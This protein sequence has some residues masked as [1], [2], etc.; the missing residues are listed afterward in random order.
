MPPGITTVLFPSTKEAYKS[1]LRWVCWLFGC[2]QQRVKMHLWPRCGWTLGICSLC[3]G[4]QKSK[5]GSQ[6]SPVTPPALTPSTPSSPAGALYLCLYPHHS[7]PLQG[8]GCSCETHCWYWDSERRGYDEHP[9]QSPRVGASGPDTFPWTQTC[10]VLYLPGFCQS[11]NW[12]LVAPG[13]AAPDSCV[14][15]RSLYPEC[16][17]GPCCCQ[18]AAASACTPPSQ[19]QDCPPC[20]CPPSLHLNWCPPCWEKLLWKRVLVNWLSQLGLEKEAVETLKEE[21]SLHLWLLHIQHRW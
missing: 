17:F 9:G 2:C 4:A 8:P 3:P 6:C 12:Q 5:C 1:S 7:L 19:S 20:C 11:S 10:S 21:G 16:S 14:F 13:A 18:A 15:S